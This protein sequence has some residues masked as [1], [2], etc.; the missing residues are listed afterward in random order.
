MD[1]TAE[2]V[3]SRNQDTGEINSVITNLEVEFAVSIP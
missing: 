2:D 3:N 1:M